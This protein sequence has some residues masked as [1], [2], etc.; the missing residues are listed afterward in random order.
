MIAEV[1]WEKAR[2]NQACR[3]RGR[4]IRAGRISFDAK[5]IVMVKTNDGS[6]ALPSLSAA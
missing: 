1:T 5:P 3:E 6:W 2:K 4:L